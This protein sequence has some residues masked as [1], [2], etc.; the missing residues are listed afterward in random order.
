[1]AAYIA[2]ALSLGNLSFVC[3]LP[4]AWGVFIRLLLLHGGGITLTLWLRQRR[5]C[6]PPHRQ[7]RGHSWRLGAIFYLAAMPF[8]MVAGILNYA[9]LRI[10]G[11]TP[12][13][14]DTALVL[15]NTESPAVRLM[16]ITAAVVTAPIFEEL[17]FRGMI[18]PLVA[19]TSGWLPA[20]L[21]VS[22]TFALFHLPTS[23]LLPLFVLAVFLSLAYIYTRSL[24]TAMILHALFNLVN[25]TLLLLLF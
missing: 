19:R 23:A 15:L 5:V 22:A 16:L 8:V 6:R 18:L 25:I 3:R 1:V 17:L 12:T 7:P 4:P 13:L 21:T 10:A 14:Q 11:H 20:I 9:V 24:R 2:I